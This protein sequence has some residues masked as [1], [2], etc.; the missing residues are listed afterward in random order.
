MCPPLPELV[1]DIDEWL[2][3]FMSAKPY[4]VKFDD[5]NRTLDVQL[6]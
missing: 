2:D 6:K 1:R 3:E 5:K 4:V